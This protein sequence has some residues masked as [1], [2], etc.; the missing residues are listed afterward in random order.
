MLSGP[1]WTKTDCHSGGMEHKSLSGH[2]EAVLVKPLSVFPPSSSPFPSSVALY[3]DVK[4][5]PTQNMNIYIFHNLF[6]DSENPHGPKGGEIGARGSE[7]T[8][9]LP[10]LPD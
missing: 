5:T 10:S 4:M 2:P 3:S 8:P 7:L 6:T 1:K 9:C